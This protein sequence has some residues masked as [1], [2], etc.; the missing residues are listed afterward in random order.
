MATIKVTSKTTS[1]VGR[2]MLFSDTKHDPNGALQVRKQKLAA[3]TRSAKHQKKP[4]GALAD[5]S[6]V[7]ALG[8]THQ[9]SR[10]SFA[11]TV[12]IERDGVTSDAFVATIEKL[13]IP[14]SRVLDIL[15]IPKSTAAYKIKNGG[16]FEGTEALASIR[17]EKLL[18]LAQSIAANSLHPDAEFFDSG[19]WLGEWI[20]H[21]QP[22]LG[23]IN[24][25]ALLDT[26][27]GGQRVYQV[28]AALESGSYQ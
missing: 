20:E 22:A 10:L 21:P 3:R 4:G 2:N 24:P 13:K 15:R 8:K 12:A 18:A 14:N 7:K 16:R 11:E 23:G 28:L 25:S 9:V 17:L 19:K 1:G 5:F 27:V 6:D 26:E